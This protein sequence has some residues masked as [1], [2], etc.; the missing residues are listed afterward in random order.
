MNPL[1]NPDK[2]VWATAFA[3][4]AVVIAAVLTRGYPLFPWA[5][6]GAAIVGGVIGWRLA[7][8]VRVRMAVAKFQAAGGVEAL[9]DRTGRELVTV[10]IPLDH[11][12]N[13]DDREFAQ[14]LGQSLEGHA[15]SEVAD[16]VATATRGGA[17]GVTVV[18]RDADTMLKEIRPFFKQHCPRGS[19]V[20]MWRISP[21]DDSQPDPTAGTWPRPK[22][23]FE[24]EELP[25][26]VEWPGL[27]G[28]GSDNLM[29]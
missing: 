14:R 1:T 29:A 27:S 10:W 11:E 22:P 28:E 4:V 21:G 16:F 23:L 7:G 5:V 2:R 18:G 17:V 20:T 24:D 8:Y 15:A 19:Y 13:D 26:D 3:A 6:S 12:V 9:L 25:E